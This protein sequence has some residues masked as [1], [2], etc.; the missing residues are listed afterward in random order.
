ML[1]ESLIESNSSNVDELGRLREQL[2]EVPDGTELPE[3]LFDQLCG[4][5][6]GP[7]LREEAVNLGHDLAARG[8]LRCR[9]PAAADLLDADHRLVE[10]LREVGALRLGDDH[11]AVLRSVERVPERL[12]VLRS[13]QVARWV[14]RCGSP[15]F[16]RDL[17]LHRPVLAS[18]YLPRL[19]HELG[20]PEQIRTAFFLGVSRLVPDG[21]REPCRGAL[22]KWLG[23]AGG[24]RLREVTEAVARL[25]R[26]FVKEWDRVVAE[27]RRGLTGRIVRFGR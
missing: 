16:V 26:P 6:L 2:A 9:V 4:E 23:R 7:V 15:V 10:L 5:L 3:R 19:C 1:Q 12:L 11:R 22:F 25:D 20:T 27:R 8:L 17:L 24:R 18:E 13:A 14:L 21:W